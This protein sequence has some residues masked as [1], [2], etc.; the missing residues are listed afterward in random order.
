[1]VMVWVKVRVKFSASVRFSVMFRYWF[2]V[3]IW[4]R[5]TVM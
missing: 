3:H 4:V 1:M 5:D 2:K